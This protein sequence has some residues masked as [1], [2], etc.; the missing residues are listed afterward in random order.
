MEVL[1]QHG[2]LEA[3]RQALTITLAKL[4]AGPD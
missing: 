3:V 1:A 2:G 4:D